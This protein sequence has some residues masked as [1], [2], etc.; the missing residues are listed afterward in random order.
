MLGREVVQP[1][2]IVFPSKLLPESADQETYIS[3]LVENS[4][5]ASE[6]AREKLQSTQVV[7][8]RNY[9]LKVNKNSYTVGDVVYVLDTAQVKGRCK[10]L[11]PTWKGPGLV[12]E[13]LSSFLYK[14]KLRGNITTMNHDRL[15]RCQDKNIPQ[16]IQRQQ[17]ELKDSNRLSDVSESG[18]YCICRDADT[19][20]FMIQCNECREWFHGSCVQVTADMAEDMDIYE[21]PQCIN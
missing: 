2:D 9:D 3:M 17:R 21:C 11:S 5:L 18:K 14:F 10:K 4:K 20:T 13:K 16:W 12:V 6:T 19:G 1:L 7:M 8:K 15:K